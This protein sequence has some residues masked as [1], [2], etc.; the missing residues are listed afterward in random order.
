[1]LAGRNNFAQRNPA[2]GAM[3]VCL[4][5]PRFRYRRSVPGYVPPIVNAGGIAVVTWVSVS[6]SAIREKP[7]IIS[8]I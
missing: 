1:M 7:Q 3:T 5:V 6:D 4:E 8:E 2:I